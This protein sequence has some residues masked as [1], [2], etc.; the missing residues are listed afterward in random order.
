MRNYLSICIITAIT[1]LST[2]CTRT[3]KTYYPDG[4]LQSIIH[5]KA[6]KEHGK[7]VYMYD[8]PNTVEME[9]EMRNGKRDGDFRRYFVNGYL[10][11]HCTYKN[12]SIEGIETMYLAN[13]TKSQE[14][15]YVRGKKNGP[16]R[17]YHISGAL[18]LEGGFKNDKFDGDWTYYD[19][20][21]MIVGEGNFVDGNGKVT[22]YNPTG[23]LMMETQYANNQKDGE[24][25]Y[26]NSNGKPYK[27]IVYKADRIVSEKV[28]STLMD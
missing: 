14:F 4:R 23:T 16:H 27:V 3:E 7:T 8:N 26:Y 25:L 2:S 10:D 15:T 9:I 11:T 1:I 21:G 13:G 6:G 18:K 12:D 5:Y 17:A 24:E 22:F 19:E 28:D 20:R